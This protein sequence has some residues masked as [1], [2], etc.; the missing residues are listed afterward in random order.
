M[1]VNCFRLVLLVL[2][3]AVFCSCRVRVLHG[4][5]AKG[6]LNAPAG[7]FSGLD[8]DVPARVTV[9]LQPGVTPS[10]KIS[11]YENVL[12]HIKPVLNGNVLQIGRDDEAGIILDKEEDLQ[13]EVW[14]PSLQ[15]LAIS[16]T[17][18]AYIH[19]ALSGAQ[20][21]MDLSGASEVVIDSMLVDDFSTE[22]S[23]ASKIQV[24]GG[25]VK[26]ADYSISGAGKILA[27]PLQAASVSIAISGA[28]K[29][30]VTA[31]E[32]LTASISGAGTVKY[33]GHPAVT[34]DIS[35]AG[36]VSEVQQ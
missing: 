25:A 23:G 31:I 4:S 22:A 33:M 12:A 24:K 29:G 18:N 9:N 2:S 17:A 28:G 1:R 36:S 34:Q 21:K 35:G 20:F 11:G 6:V 3:L 19:G 13:I 5:G 8:V 15:S 32:K 14:V 27:F 7:A 30:E 16:G 10:A 26:Q